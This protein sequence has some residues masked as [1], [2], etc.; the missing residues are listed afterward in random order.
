[1]AKH[2]AMVQTY[3]RFGISLKYQACEAQI[4]FNTSENK[5]FLLYGN[6]SELD[7]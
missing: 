7:G 1:M 3:T 2:C 5:F 4:L 6:R